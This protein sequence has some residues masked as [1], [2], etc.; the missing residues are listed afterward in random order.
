MLTQET[1]SPRAP[2]G[3]CEPG[4]GCHALPRPAR[5]ESF[6]PSPL[7]SANPSHR[8]GQRLPEPS[9]PSCP[10]QVGSPEVQSP[11]SRSDQA[12]QPGH[13][14]RP[15]H[16]HIPCIAQLDDAGHPSSFHH[17]FRLSVTQTRKHR[18]YGLCK[19]SALAFGAFLAHSRP[20]LSL[21]FM[22]LHLPVTLPPANILPSPQA[23]ISRVHRLRPPN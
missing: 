2:T 21:T 6:R 10:R 3:R 11:H 16:L 8:H 13:D 12:Q 4:L 1:D 22:R 19:I 23:M 14:L 15:K 9:Y 20:G 17:V 5:E 18:R 7:L